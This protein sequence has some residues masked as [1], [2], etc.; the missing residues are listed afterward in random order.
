MPEFDSYVQGGAEF[1]L[2][3]GSKNK[4]KKA[5]KDAIKADPS[6]VY[7]YDTSAFGSKFSGP[8]N[9]LPEGVCFNVVGPDPYSRRDWYAS[10]YKGRN[11]MVCT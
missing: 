6:K 9:A 7:M 1:P 4:T 8:A 3:N 11:G 10:V 5:L 2:T